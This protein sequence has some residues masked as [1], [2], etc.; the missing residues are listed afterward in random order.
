[1][2]LDIRLE[3]MVWMAAQMLH[4]VCIP[5][6][7]C[8]ALPQVLFCLIFAFNYPVWLFDPSVTSLIAGT[9]KACRCLHGVPLFLLEAKKTLVEVEL[10]VPKAALFPAPAQGWPC[11]LQPLGC[12][13][14]SWCP[15]PAGQRAGSSWGQV[16]ALLS[17]C[18]AGASRVTSSSVFLWWK[19]LSKLFTQLCFPRLWSLSLGQSLCPLSLRGAR[20]ALLPLCQCVHPKGMASGVFQQSG[21]T[22]WTPGAASTLKVTPMAAADLMR[23]PVGQQTAATAV[24][25]GLHIPESTWQLLNLTKHR[26]IKIK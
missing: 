6:G 5:A 2:D 23:L 26:K 17:V 24:V 7:P 11:V 10:K 4:W 15:V 3:L 9:A 16:A 21:H 19:V 12:D 14:A 22:V 1:M 8:S 18:S 13:C 20:A 25:V